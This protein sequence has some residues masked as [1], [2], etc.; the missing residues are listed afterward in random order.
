MEGGLSVST[1]IKK[2][3]EGGEQLQ[4]ANT[5]AEKLKAK[6]RAMYENMMRKLQ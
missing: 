4:K 3:M 5:M 6:G 1:V 2:A